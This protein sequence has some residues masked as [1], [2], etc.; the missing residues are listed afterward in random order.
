MP[1]RKFN[2]ASELID[3]ILNLLEEGEEADVREVS[4]EI[5]FDESETRETLEILEMMGLVKNLARPSS[6]GTETLKVS[7]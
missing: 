6:F 4:H 7:A 3:E 5:G 2:D 1:E